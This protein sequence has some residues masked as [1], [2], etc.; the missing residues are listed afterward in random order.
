M[1]AHVYDGPLAQFDHAK[2]VSSCSH[3][4]GAGA[5]ADDRDHRSCAGA[6]S[7]TT[8]EQLAEFFAQHPDWMIS[9]GRLVRRYDFASFDESVAFLNW[10][11]GVSR[12]ANHHPDIHLENKRTVYLVLW[13]HKANALTELDLQFASHADAVARDQSPAVTS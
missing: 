5:H 13:T 8:A 1:G 6:L 10:V 2:L 3:E 9:D 11:I 4:P 12:E 7:A